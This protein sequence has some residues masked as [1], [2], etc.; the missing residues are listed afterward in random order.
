[1]KFTNRFLSAIITLSLLVS[2]FGFEFAV[3]NSI[4][5]YVTA[6]VAAVDDLST[7]IAITFSETV[8][9]T[10][11]MGDIKLVK[12]ASAEEVTDAVIAPNTSGIKITLGSKL[13]ADT[14]YAVVLPNGIETE[15]GKNFETNMI[16][17]TVS[18]SVKH[19]PQEK[20]RQY[21]ADFEAIPADDTYAGSKTHW[22][23]YLHD[24]GS[25]TASVCKVIVGA[26]GTDTKTLQFTE[27]KEWVQAYF[28][29]D[30]GDAKW[31][32]DSIDYTRLIVC[33]DFLLPE[34]VET[35]NFI[36]GFC[37]SSNKF[38]IG[39]QFFI[40]KN[41]NFCVNKVD[42]KFDRSTF[43]KISVGIEANKWYKVTALIDMEARKIS[44][45]LDGTYLYSAPLHKTNAPDG[46]KF[47]GLGLQAT[48]IAT[49]VVRYVDNISVGEATAKTIKPISFR[50]TDNKGKVY[51]PNATDT[52]VFMKKADIRFTG[53]I[54]LSTVDNTTLKITDGENNIAWGN[55]T[56]DFE[57]N[58]LCIDILDSFTKNKTYSVIASAIK[59]INGA[60]IED[61]T[62][63]LKTTANGEFE[64]DEISIYTSG[65]EKIE[66]ISDITEN[67]T[68]RAHIKIANT[69]DASVTGIKAAITSYSNGVL[70]DTKQ[71]IVDALAGQ[72]TPIQ[73]LAIN[74]GSLS[75]GVIVVTITD[76]NNI[77]L[78]DAYKIGS[79]TCEVG[80]WT[81]EFE[82]VATKNQNV[83]V[84]VEAPVDSQK[85]IVYRDQL[86]ADDNGK[87]KGSF[88][89]SINAE[90]GIYTF[91]WKDNAG[92]SGTFEKF[93]NNVYKGQTEKNNIENIVENTT[94]MT[95]D[96][97]IIAI[98]TIIEDK[99]Y[100]LG[101]DIPTEEYEALDKKY[102]AKMIYD[103]L[104]VNG[105]IEDDIITLSTRIASVKAGKTTNLF[106]YA[107]VLKLD[108]SPIKDFYKKDY[109][110][111]QMEEKI[112]KALKGSN[113]GV[114][115]AAILSVSCY[116][117]EIDGFYDALTEQFVLAVVS[118]PDG[119]DNIKAVMK[120][121]STEIGSGAKGSDAAYKAV[122]YNT[123][124]SY[125]DLK[126]AFDKANTTTKP[127]T[128]SGGGGGEAKEFTNVTPV[129]IGEADSTT[130][131]VNTPL[132]NNIFTDLDS[133]EWATE[134][135]VYLAEKKI[136]NGK[137]ADKY[138][139]NDFVTREEACKII[140][141]AFDLEGDESKIVK[142]TDL[143]DWSKGYVSIAYACGV[144]NGYDEYNFGAKDKITRQDLAVMIYR[145][146][147]LCGYEFT[148]SNTDAFTDSSY[149]ADY[150]VEGIGALNEKGYIN[151]VG[152]GRF[153]PLAAATRAELAQIVYNIIR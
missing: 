46:S 122:M 68:I 75:N 30:T 43:E 6:T 126:N 28:R 56:F 84:E 1:M 121:F 35:G 81:V 107:T 51:G 74:A 63:T 31:W 16:Y 149:I 82:N 49:N 25:E 15:D 66:N 86:V 8:S 113:Y 10:N 64:V 138:Y 110:T 37:S 59:D 60:T 89:L 118:A 11:A 4:S 33:F 150:A 100:D 21:T 73:G 148:E 20:A 111:I 78:C 137:E 101:I 52:S 58:T 130:N 133:V 123:Y 19:L 114:S 12:S 134:A 88:K 65:G 103:Y 120:A 129:V 42:E 106:D 27:T 119:L 39:G 127:I 72:I 136:V 131:K 128:P 34:L 41:G 55:P 7:S 92:K 142:F 70:C 57:T 115:Q 36:M 2:C 44:Y 29:G 45:W 61:Y 139:P 102:I 95:K 151:G 18:R 145:T 94:E 93:F 144:A 62:A 3:A 53:D 77:P 98:K 135:I 140:A 143:S 91:N 109:V 26:D 87:V 132:H 9:Y 17:F 96:T 76:S 69:A 152:D 83:Y 23:K 14:E 40:D 71:V 104:I 117:N 108:E 90:S 50:M 105:N 54:N 48:H 24:G 5:D 13:D 47:S 125:T 99:K 141:L 67:D 124:S 116:G 97:D 112:T 80:D 147:K 153:A 79:Y 22:K 32:K 38:G 85:P 146:A